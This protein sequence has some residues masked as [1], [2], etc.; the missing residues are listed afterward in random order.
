[1]IKNKKMIL[2]KYYLLSVTTPSLLMSPVIFAELM[3]ISVPGTAVIA[4]PVVEVIVPPY[5]LLRN[6]IFTNT[7]IYNFG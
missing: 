3:T 4:T 1:M 5:L 2:I 7:W 6:L